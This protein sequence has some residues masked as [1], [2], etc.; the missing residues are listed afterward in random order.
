M[1]LRY[2]PHRIARDASRWLPTSRSEGSFQ[3]DVRQRAC[4]AWSGRECW[5]PVDVMPVSIAPELTAEYGYDA[6]CIA[7]L[8]A[9]DA[10]PDEPLLESAHRWL[11][12]VHERSEAAAA[13]A[14]NDPECSAWDAAP[15]LSAAFAA[16][17]HL[18]LRSHAYPALAA[19]R[20]AW[21]QAP[22]GPAVPGAGVR[23]IW[24]LLL[25]FAP[26]LARAFLERTG[27]WP[28]PSLEKLAEPFLPMRAVR[29]ALERGGW[30]WVVVDACRFETE[31]GS[32]IAGIG[33]ITEALGDRP[34]TL[35]SEGEGWRVCLN[36]PPT[37]VASS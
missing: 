36:R 32:E 10:L 29:V 20:K 12:L 3:A 7:S 31:P 6:V 18:V 34:W 35:R 24:S 26:L 14:T 21:K 19:V 25:P 16:R 5:L 22:A 17:D 11:S 23:L 27:D 15:W 2:N 1:S 28:T 37:T 30:N 33:W 13:A 4:Q 8:T 9:G